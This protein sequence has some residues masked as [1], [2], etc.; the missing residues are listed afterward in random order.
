MITKYLGID[1]GA[2]GGYGLIDHAGNFIEC[3]SIQDFI[4]CQH[5]K[6]Y[7][8]WIEHQRIRG[9]D[10]KANVFNLQ[11]LLVNY[12][13][14]RGL[15]LAKGIAW[16]QVEPISWQAHYGLIMPRGLKSTRGKLKAIKNDMILAMARTLFPQAPLTRKKDDGRA[17]GLLLAEYGRQRLLLPKNM[18]LFG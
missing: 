13:E 4:N 8:A 12:G 1:P 3:G 18:Q 10:S 7:F 16:E 6:Q 5:D 11:H 17:V 2:N 14:W 9:N 15:L